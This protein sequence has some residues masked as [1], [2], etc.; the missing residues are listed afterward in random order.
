[1][2]VGDTLWW[3]EHDHR[4]SSGRAR[5]VVVV[6]MGRKWAV[7]RDS[8]SPN[9]PTYRV[10]IADGCVDGGQYAS[11]AKCWPSQAA[12]DT[13]RILCVAWDEF[14]SLVRSQYRPPEGITLARI[15]AARKAIVGEPPDA[16]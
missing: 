6:S 15:R 4:R 10:C 5:E 11:P 16:S 13:H 8:D 14:F 7:V 12:Y 3:V 9:G 2:K 1:M